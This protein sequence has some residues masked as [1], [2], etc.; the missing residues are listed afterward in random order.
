MEEDICE[1]LINFL[2]IILLTVFSNQGICY[3][4]FICVRMNG[5]V[6]SSYG[7]TVSH[8][9]QEGSLL[10][11]DAVCEPHALISGSMSP[12]HYTNI[13]LWFKEDEPYYDASCYFWCTETGHLPSATGEVSIGDPTLESTIVSGSLC[14]TY[15]LGL[16][17]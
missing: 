8:K 15:K 14:V 12:G 9:N 1:T 17:P 16:S 2:K 7:I 6:C 3:S 13:N 10:K 11:Q 5:N 4:N